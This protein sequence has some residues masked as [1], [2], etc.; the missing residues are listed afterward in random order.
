MSWWRHHLLRLELAPLFDILQTMMKT[1]QE[2]YASIY[3]WMMIGVLIS[4]V[5][6]WLT[7]NSPLAVIYST[8]WYFYGVVGIQLAILLGVQWGIR[9][10]SA[11]QA[12]FLYLFYTFLNGVTMAGFL[13]YFL[14]TDPELLL[15]IFGAAAAMFAL[16]A[17]LG[18]YTTYDMSG[19]GTFLIAGVWGVFLASIANAFFQSDPFSYVISAVALVIFAALTVYDNQYY[20]QLF[21]D[22]QSEEDQS[23]F[24]TLGALHMY[25]NFI[26]IFQSLLNLA[27]LGQ[28]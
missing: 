12:F 3:R 7:M 23:K 28:D 1:V 25:I 16:L 27:R 26:M 2:F 21:A 8:S 14:N 10:V 6:A 22:L 24:S 19:W 9:R 20:K 5:A 17:V 11:A 13:A 18:Y 15:I 4:A